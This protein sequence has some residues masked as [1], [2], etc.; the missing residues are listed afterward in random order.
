MNLR[1]L[2]LLI[3][4]AM[5]MLGVRA[6]DLWQGLAQ[7]AT[8]ETAETQ[9]AP[10]PPDTQPAA[11]GA[12]PAPA[13]VRPVDPFSLTDSEIELLQ[14]LSARREALEQRSLELEQRAVLLSAAEARIEERIQEL[15]ALQANIEGMIEQ[16]DE[17]QEAQLR[18]LVKIYESMKPKEAARIF[19]ELDMTVLLEVID[20][21]KER[22][23][24]PILAKMNP[25]KAKEVTVELADKHKLPLRR[26]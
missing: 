8:A 18:S 23:S 9:V 4:A 16:R 5:V 19:E 1:L 21:M 12:E 17:K 7:A 20:R 15:K 6:G 24:A 25:D 10:P 2:P 22:K 14:K 3:V 13:E 11:A 26:N